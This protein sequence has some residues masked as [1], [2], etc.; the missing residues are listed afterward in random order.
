MRAA[1]TSALSYCTLRLMNSFRDVIDLWGPR[2][3]MAADLGN[4]PVTI[5]SWWQRD[6]IRAEWFCSVVAAAQKRGFD[7]VTVDLLAQ[8]AEKRAR[9]RAEVA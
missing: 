7:G 3:E 2:G 9:E 8:L 4:S 5:S 1:L 6:S